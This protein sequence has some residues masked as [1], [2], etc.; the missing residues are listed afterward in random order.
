LKYEPEDLLSAADIAKIARATPQAVSN[1]RARHSEFPQPVAG[2][3]RRPLFAYSEVV[4]WLKQ[5]N[6]FVGDLQSSQLSF[7]R[8]I[9]SFSRAYSKIEILTCAGISMALIKISR[10]LQQ[11]EGLSKLGVAGNAEVVAAM[12]RDGVEEIKNQGREFTDFEIAVSNASTEFGEVFHGWVHSSSWRE[13]RSF[14]VTKYALGEDLTQEFQKLLGIFDSNFP[15]GWN[16]SDAFLELQDAVF[17][18]FESQ[19]A[20]ADSV[21]DLFGGIGNFAFAVARNSDSSKRV[22]LLQADTQYSAIN[23]ARKVFEGVEV[24]IVELNNPSRLAES[25]LKQKFDFVFDGGAHVENGSLETIFGSLGIVELA[26][27]R[28]SL[29]RLGLA[30][31]LSTEDAIGVCVQTEESL[32]SRAFGDV[33]F[34]SK[35]LAAG[36]IMGVLDIPQVPSKQPHMLKTHY[37]LAIQG[38]SGTKRDGVTFVSQ[39]QDLVGTQR[40]IVARLTESID[41]L[42]E[43][44]SSD[45]GVN[46]VSLEDLLSS[47][48]QLVG[49]FYGQYS[50][51]EELSSEF[52][53]MDV[54]ASVSSVTAML[55]GEAKTMFSGAVH[56]TVTIREGV[57]KSY[58]KVLGVRHRDHGDDEDSS[59]LEIIS[60]AWIESQHPQASRV[61]RPIVGLLKLEP[62]DVLLFTDAD[63]VH[64]RVWESDVR[65]VLVEFG[66]LILRPN[67]EFLSPKY[68]AWSLRGRSNAALLGS[69]GRLR[70]GIF[71]KFM[72]SVP[73]LENQ[74]ALI[75][76]FELIEKIELELLEAKKNLQEM[77]VKIETN[78]ALGGVSIGYSPQE[79]YPMQ[80]SDVLKLLSIFEEG[81]DR[82]G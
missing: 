41:L 27:S 52:D 56:D 47:Q 10:D 70:F 60:R 42:L 35:L 32:A 13:M 15:P 23:R 3:D 61:F 8:Q 39:R 81:K 34:R 43:F 63:G 20:A 64:S 29:P 24:E 25:I 17:A 77:K 73:P 80:P 1:W 51:A 5:N 55:L 76:K 46:V 12:A 28:T 7:E 74:L 48:S 31:Q 26:R 19:I 6:K 2:T 30:D 66:I 71:D 18:S 45:E 54:H 36:Q 22:V 11:K 9:R 68:L 65:N 16:R 4:D 58:L 79:I 62:G 75:D 40:E 49:R 69:G 67:L 53:F 57:R 82:E 72:F 38:K 78:L 33:L 21:I 37:L 50:E 59:A 14:F 44:D